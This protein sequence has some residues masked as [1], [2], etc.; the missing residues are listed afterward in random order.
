MSK[1]TP[2]RQSK[3]WLDGGCPAGVLAILDSGAKCA[4]RYTVIYK[5]PVCGKTYADMILGFRGMSAAP[6]HPQGVG[7]YGELKAYE[8]AGL[9]YRSRSCKWSDLPADVQK[10]VRQDLSGERNT[11][12]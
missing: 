1:Y 3:R 11:H 10:C 2:R 12:V 6:F 8:A 7:M 5:D 9:R 4:D